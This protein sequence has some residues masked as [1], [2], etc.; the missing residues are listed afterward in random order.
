MKTPGKP[1]RAPLRLRWKPVR[2]RNPI[3]VAF[4]AILLI[5]GLL[6]A[7]ANADDLPV[8]GGGTGYT[9]YF[10]EAAGLKSGQ[11][12][13]VAGVKVGKV[14]GVRLD[15]PKVR[16]S[17]RVRKTWIG[18]R[19]TATIMIKTL[20]GGKFL[21]LDPLG[22]T[23]QDPGT[24]IP[25]SRTVAPYDVMQ[26][27][28]DLGGTLGRLDT[29][30]I[31]ESLTV[32]SRTF[33]NTPPSVGKALDGLSALSTSI[34]SRD[35]QLAD[36]L[37]GTKRLS[38]TLVSQNSQFESLLKDGNLLLAELTRRRQAIH[39]LLTGAAELGEQLRHLVDDNDTDLHSALTHLDKVTDVL[40]RNQS[41][42]DRALSLTGTYIRLFNNAA[43]NG[44]W[45]DG[46]LCGAVPPDYVTGS[47]S[48][49]TPPSTCLPPRAGGR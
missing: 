34:S 21:A 19:T 40:T 36:L 43:G 33:T 48:A 2:E 30:K 26:A 4:V 42:L 23:E 14:T 39:A 49:Y 25:L 38:S 41:D 20:L 5:I 15:G 22:R 13:R 12:V 35:A 1:G 17:F 32:L 8:I 45:V 3:A 11:E 16:V 18:D 46:Y 47:G 10:S 37:A 44:R 28:N 24:P 27:F 9:A 29:G 31:A 6:A 7:A